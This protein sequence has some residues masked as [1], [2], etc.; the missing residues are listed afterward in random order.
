[1]LNPFPRTALVAA[2]LLLV[3]LWQYAAAEPVIVGPTAPVPIGGFCDVTIT[4]LDNRD[5]LA[6]V[7]VPEIP[8][9]VYAVWGSGDPILSVPT[10]AAGT[11]TLVVSYVEGGKP[12]LKKVVLVIGMPTPPVPPTPEP[13]PPVPPGPSGLRVL[14]LEE[15]ADR[16]GLPRGQL[17]AITSTAIRDYVKS[18]A[19]DA[20]RL[21]DDDLNAE[22]MVGW[23]DAWKASYEQA[24]RLSEGVL[25]FIM[26][27]NGTTGTAVKLPDTEAATLELIRRYGG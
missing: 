6:W 8:V 18:K 19:Q 12:I 13:D 2:A 27:T 1:M 24:K 22:G 3:P 17:A 23:S 26:V 25:P 20:F 4:G 5:A 16:P 7:T 11:W 9:R 21:L 14:I 15:S 10:N